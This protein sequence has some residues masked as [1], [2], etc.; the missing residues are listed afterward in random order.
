[1]FADVVIKDLDRGHE[2]C[3]GES[4]MDGGGTGEATWCYV[5]RLLV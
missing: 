3:G 2:L 1:M 4:M 5:S